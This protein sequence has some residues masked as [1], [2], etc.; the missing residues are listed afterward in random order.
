MSIA[1]LKPNFRGDWTPLVSAVSQAIEVLESKP[2]RTFE[3]GF[4]DNGAVHNL[5]V[6][7]RWDRVRGIVFEIPETPFIKGA[8]TKRQETNLLLMGWRRSRTKEAITYSYALHGKLRT[9]F[10]AGSVIDATR[11]IL[12]DKPD[13]WFELQIDGQLIT[14]VNSDLF[15]AHEKI[16]G[17]FRTKF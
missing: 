9:D 7:G 4:F 11:E 2:H 10:L 16:I 1:K 12:G 6:I 13:T 17:R 14:K 5:S 8:L 15:E 3:M